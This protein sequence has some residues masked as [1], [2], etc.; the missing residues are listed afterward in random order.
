[1][2]A[3]RT[4]AL[5]A[6]LALGTASAQAAP[7]DN[8]DVKITSLSVAGVPGSAQST[9]VGASAC[10][11]AFAGSAIPL[12]GTSGGSNLGYYGD[13]LFNGAGQGGRGHGTALFPDG[14][15]S[16]Q[17]TATDLNGDGKKDPGW[18]YLGSWTPGAGN[19]FKAALING[20]AIIGNNWFNATMN[21]AGNGGTWSFLPPSNVVSLL[22]PI[23]GSNLFDQFA[24]SF[25]SGSTFAAYDFTAA[26]LGLPV[27]SSTIYNFSGSWDMSK[28]LINGGGNAGA[29]SHIDL[30]VRDPIGPR[31]DVPEPGT[32][33]LL[34]AAIAGTALYRRRQR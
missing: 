13:G 22:E 20:Q 27:S 24:L 25:M 26:G 14:I 12:P 4:L 5:T 21:S 34:L 16:G 7:C 2:I 17:Y 1:M 3:F 11:G 23:F 28:T 19:G 30:Y 9:S 32:L 6:L 29:L 15:F 8:A 18:I 31:R 10:V 33:G